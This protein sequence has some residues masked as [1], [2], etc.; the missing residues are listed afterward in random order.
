MTPALDGL[1]FDRAWICAST[2]AAAAAVS[3]AVLA[4]VVGR[5]LR[6]RPAPLRYGLLLAALLAML[7]SAAAP[8]VASAEPQPGVTKKGFRLFAR[9]LDDRRLVLLSDLGEEAVEELEFGYAASPEVVERLAHRAE[10]LVVLAEADRCL[11]KPLD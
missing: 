8:N 10:R 3:V 4:L 2:G 7:A 5:S 9:A 6:G 11:P 1:L